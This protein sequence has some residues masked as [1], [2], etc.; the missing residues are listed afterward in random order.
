M[1]VEIRDSL[2]WLYP[3]STVTSR[4]RLSTKLDVARGGTAAVHLLLDEL[5]VG[6]TLRVSLRRSGRPERSAQWFRLVD[7]PVEENTGADGFVEPK[8]KR[9]KWV[10]RRAP[11]RVFDAM[12][13]ISRSS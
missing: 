2:E 7:V 5:E 12:E 10:T 8:G 1:R 13:P 9:N 3:D 11:F 6:S 4:P